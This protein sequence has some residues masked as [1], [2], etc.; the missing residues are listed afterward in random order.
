MTALDA[1]PLL[2]SLC[3]ARLLSATAAARTRNARVI[4]AEVILSVRP[5][6]ATT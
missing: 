3:C 5:C 2:D 4:R 6:A 1:V